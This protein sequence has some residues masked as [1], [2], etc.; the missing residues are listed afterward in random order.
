[1]VFFYELSQYLMLA[2]LVYH[3]FYRTPG[4][5]CMIYNLWPNICSMILMKSHC[6]CF[7]SQLCSQ[8]EQLEQENTSLRDGK[9]PQATAPSPTPSSG[10]VDGELLRLQAENSALLKKMAGTWTKQGCFYC[11][12]LPELT[13][14]K[15]KCLK[16]KYLI[17]LV[18]NYSTFCS[19]T[20]I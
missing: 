16:I 11:T 3:L 9:G 20:H 2:L 17:D 12:D 13:K 18:F 14:Q 8:I 15:N 10:P 1:M 7:P 5:F 4:S 19:H 6:V